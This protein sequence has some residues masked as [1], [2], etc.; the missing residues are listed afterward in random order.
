M[1]LALGWPLFPCRSSP[2]G[3]LNKDGTPKRDEKAPLTLHGFKD[4]TLD[5]ST[6]EAWAKANP[7]C[8]WGTPTSAERAAVDVDPRHGGYETLK[9]LTDAHGPMPETIITETGGGGLHIWM[10]FPEGTGS[11][12]NA[13]GEGIDL[14]AEGGYVIVP[15]S[16]IAIPEHAH[17]YR[18]KA[19]AKPWEMAIAQAPAWMANMLIANAKPTKP[20]AIAPSAWTVEAEADLRTHQGSHE[21]QRRVTL[22]RLVGTALGNGLKAEEL[23]ELARAW[24]SRC[25]P[26]FAEW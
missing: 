21:G 2:S 4:A 1:Y 3:Q 18:F 22:C 13:F 12:P 24:A 25:Q 5:R 14:K 20:T 7:N 8:A 16:R 9:A 26:P 17:A 19:G 23:W 11:K 10:S 15:P 6:I